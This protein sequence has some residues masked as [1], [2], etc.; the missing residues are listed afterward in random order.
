MY[1]TDVG[2]IPISVSV[3]I[4]VL[5]ALVWFG[6]YSFLIYHTSERYTLVLYQQYHTV[7]HYTSYHIHAT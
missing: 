3:Y 5:S 4:Y 7:T 1:I 2:N 6:M